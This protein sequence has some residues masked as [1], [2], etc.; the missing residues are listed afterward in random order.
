MNGYR[1]EKSVEVLPGPATASA[2]PR[3]SSSG[4]RLFR[5]AIALFGTFFVFNLLTHGPAFTKVSKGCHGLKNYLPGH[6][7]KGGHQHPFPPIDGWI[8]YDGTTHF[9]LEPSE[10][11]GFSVT[12]SRAFGG[13]VFETSKLS[14]KVII[15]LDI[16]TNIGDI[17]G[18]VSVTQKDG[19]LTVDTPT[20]GKL[21]THASAKILI[22]S[23]IIGTFGLPSFDVN[24]PRHMVDFSQLPESLEIGSLAIRVAKGFVKAGPVHTNTTKLDI[25]K[26]ALRGS[27]TSG[28]YY[29]G[30]TVAK[31]NV[32]L[33]IPSIS[34]G[35]EGTVFVYLGNGH[36][37]GNFAVHNSTTLDV[38]SGSIY[39]SVDFKHA[40]TR[41]ELSTK[42]AHGD[43]RVYVSSIAAERLFKSYH[44]SIAGDQLITYPSNF[45]GTIDARG[46]LGGI[47]LEGDDLEVEKVIGGMTA[48][49]GDPER[50]SVSVKA[51]KGS[52][53]ILV[54]DE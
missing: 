51:V 49:K 37:K 41:A 29:T 17:G 27:L 34:S 54:G 8:P 2:T 32:T 14:D 31:G 28:R 19:Y 21:K 22:P 15:D 9:E 4:S 25:A 33:D 40:E 11:S 30:I 45:Q 46:I 53:D 47:K 39:V 10:A 35:N 38:A 20:T 13:V 42:I 52:L 26:G 43:A 5:F 7:D 1:D 18:E 16:K 23:N 48:T 50:N 12:G 24:V 6:F 3:R 36:L 44:T